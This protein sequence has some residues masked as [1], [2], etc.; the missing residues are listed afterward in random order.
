MTTDRDTLSAIRSGLATALAMADAA[1]ALPPAP[2]VIPPP[3]GPVESPDGTTLTPGTGAVLTGTGDVWMLAADTT[4]MRNGADAYNDW[5][6][7]KLTYR[8]KTV[9]IDGLDGNSYQWNSTA[10]AFLPATAS[11]PGPTKPVAAPSGPSIAVGP[12]GDLSAA[13][14]QARSGSV[15]AITLSG[16]FNLTSSIVLTSQDSGTT[17]QSDGTAVIDGGGSLDG[18]FVL[19]GAKDVTLDGLTIQNFNALAVFSKAASPGLTLKN[20]DIGHQASGNSALGFSGWAPA[21]GVSGKNIT[22]SHCYIHDV[23]SMGIGAYAYQAADSIDGLLIDGCAVIR[24]VQS[25][26][27]GGGIYTNMHAS[28]LNGGKISITNNLVAQCGSPSTW[29]VHDIYLDDTTCNATVTGNICGAYAPNTGK[30]GNPYPLNSLNLVFMT[31]GTKNTVTG[32]ILDLGVDGTANACTFAGPAG[33]GN[34][35]NVFSGNIVVGHFSGPQ[36][37]NSSGKQAQY[38]QDPGG[39]SN[40]QIKGNTYWNYGGGQ[41]RTDG[42]SVGESDN[43]PHIA[44]PQL[45][46]PSYSVGNPPAG[47]VAIVGGWGPPGWTQ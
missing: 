31:Y 46:L 12:G 9:F 44:D 20:L 28:G 43:P 32:N 38:V 17:W 35:D 47:W 40:V 36:T 39:Q 27:D 16:R 34:C 23:P 10:Q 18:V 37:G 26:S 11:Q 24:A 19:D 1:L 3:S 2:V 7:H 15:K 29:G 22:I 33:Q 4:I 42:T 14:K 13:Q 21:I 6:S 8:N 41:M 45:V 25:V 30:N 5:Q